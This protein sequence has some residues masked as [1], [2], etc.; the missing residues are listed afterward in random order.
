MPSDI[1]QR[2]GVSE[3]STAT[4][5]FVPSS[6][7]SCPS[8]EA[9]CE[10]FTDL[11]AERQG[12]GETLQHYSKIKACEVAPS[13]P[14]PRNEFYSWFGSDQS[15]GSR[16]VKFQ[17][18]HETP[19]NPYPKCAPG[20]VGAAAVCDCASTVTGMNDPVKGTCREFINVNGSTSK[21]WTD[22]LVY[23]VAAGTATRIGARSGEHLF[24]FAEFEQKLPSKE[25]RLPR[26]SRAVCR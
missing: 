19:I 6:A 4:A 5:I 15:G 11:D 1:E 16:L 14:D 22:L 3:A 8:A 23:P 20:A 13:S 24:T 9:G 17:Y 25:R 12:S 21:R 2:F 7:A 10:E 18:A 26:V